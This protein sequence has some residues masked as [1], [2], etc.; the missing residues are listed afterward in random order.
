MSTEPT[1]ALAG[2]RLMQRRLMLSLSQDQVAAAIGV[3]YQQVQKYER[4]LNRL[5]AGRLRQLADF[6]DVPVSYFFEDATDP[7]FRPDRDT[8]ETMALYQAL[9]PPVRANLRQLM[10]TLL[11]QTQAQGE[12]QDRA[13][14]DAA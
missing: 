2:R 1:N 4:G 8:L 12:A 9:P 6:L 14:D 13:R 11:A 10:Q 5:T 7:G 3:T